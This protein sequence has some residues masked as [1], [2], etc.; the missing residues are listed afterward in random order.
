MGDKACAVPYNGE[1]NAH[2]ALSLA[3]LVALVPAPIHLLRRPG[4]R[5]GA[6]WL[7]LGVAVAGPL[8]VAIDRLWNGWLT[9]LS[10]ALW[11]SI[12]ASLVAYL[13]V[14]MVT[15]SGWRLTPLLLPYLLL[16]G[17]GAI[18]ADRLPSHPLNSL[19]SP[20]W[21]EVHIAFSIATY[22]LL[23]IAAVAGLAVFVQEASLKRPRLGLLS[24]RLPAIADA[25]R[26]QIALLT[27]TAIVLGIGL[28][29]GIVNQMQ[30]SG[31]M[32]VFNHKTL[33]AL[34]GFAVIVALLGVHF[35]TGL[36]GRRA[37]RLA[38]IAYLLVTLA[39]PGVKFVTDVLLS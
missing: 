4:D 29:T 37:A 14:C 24:A 13:I 5:D 3:A 16:F 35:R 9:N 15:R 11:A 22:A 36:R 19:A 30:V 6:F 2:F 21:L 25:E 28:V 23:T 31:Q 33:L 12:A 27:A 32:L 34:L 38:L 10:A 17:I 39:Y 26:L 1:M 20:S 18:F 7:L 8:V